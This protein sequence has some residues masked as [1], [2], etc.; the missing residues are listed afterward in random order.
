MPFLSGSQLCPVDMFQL[1]IDKLNPDYKWFWQRPKRGRL[2]YTDSLWYDRMRLGHD[3]IDGFM[4]TI[5]KEAQLSKRYTNHSIRSTAMGI[6]AEHFEGRH[7]I[8]LSGHKSEST[9]KQ[10]VRRLPEKKK[11]EMCNKL[12]ETALP[13]K[14]PKVVEKKFQFKSTH[15]AT[16]SQPPQNSNP[17]PAPTVPQ[18]NVENTL[19][20]DI[21]AVPEEP[22]D[23]MLINFLAQFDPVTENPPAQPLMPINVQN[24]N[25]VNNVQNNVNPNQQVIPN[26][27][28][29]GNSTVTINYNFNK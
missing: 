21:Q 1:Y 17:P 20:F 23:D 6:L 10:Y 29:G 12:A 19:E 13:A 2:H 18:E 9:I 25:N 7:V 4:A 28:F 11:L 27:Y 24:N 14:Q 22:N 3:P 8:G 5:S 15:S 26:M 16:I